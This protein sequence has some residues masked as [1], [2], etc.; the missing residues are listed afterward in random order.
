M[1]F[2]IRKKEEIF[3]LLFSRSGYIRRAEAWV[4][5]KRSDSLYKK[6]EDGQTI[7]LYI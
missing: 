6:N 2:P 1:F 7:S 3:W 5:S 4:I